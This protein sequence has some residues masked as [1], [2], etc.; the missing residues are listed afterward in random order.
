MFDRLRRDLAFGL[1]THLRTPLVTAV[2][3]CTLALGIASAGVSFSLMNALFI[4][5]LPI[6]GPDRFVRVY[7]QREGSPQ[8]LPISYRELRDLGDLREVFAGAVAEQPA[9][10]T[11]GAAGAYDRVWGEIV[12]ERY[13]ALLGVEPAYGRFFSTS[14]E[15][16]GE[17]VIVI[18]HG[19][20]QRRFGGNPEALNS[21]VRVDARLMRIIGVA[22]PAFRGTIVAFESDLWVPI[23]SAPTRHSETADRADRGYFVIARLTEDSG[24]GRAR[25]AVDAL[26]HRLQQEYPATNRGIRLIAF[27]ESE[28]RVPPPFRDGVLGFSTVAVAVAL[29]VTAIACANV[30]GM[31]L[32]RAAARRTEIG[33]RLALGASRRRIIAQ[34]LTEAAMLSLA[35][36]TIGVTVA[37]LLT[38]A[39]SRLQVPIARGA[40][41]SLDV[42]MDSRVLA[43]S[44]AV[45][46]L[47]GVLFGLVPALEASRPNLVGILKAGGPGS[48]RHRSLAG[49]IFLA[50]QIALSML[51]LITG[52]LFV[53][54]LQHGRAIDLGFDPANVV[55]SAVDIRGS[56]YSPAE[57]QGFWTT[58]IDEIRRLP[59]TES[60]SLTARLPLELGIVTLS[61]GPEGFQPAGDRGWPSSEFA[62]VDPDFFD[63]LRI[64]L[65][66]GRDFTDRDTGGA[67]PVIIVNDV[68]ARQFWGE[69]RAVGRHVINPEGERFE[70]VGEVR[71]SKYLSVG[72]DPKPYVYF[73]LRQGMSHAMTI[74]AR[75]TGDS[76][77]HIRAIVAAVRR[78]DP[79]APLFDVAP[80]SDRVTRSLAATSG[81]VA[82]LGIISLMA[83]ALTSLGLFGAVAQ[84][85][86]RRTYEIGVRRAL[87]A[88]DRNVIWVVV[89]DV[90][91][92]VAAGLLLGIALALV[93]G[94][95]L[96]VLLYNV[97]PSDPLVFF[98]APLVLL[99]VAL[100]SAWLP[101]YRATRIN[102]ATALRYD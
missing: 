29:L 83:L 92:L 81:G 5:P 78:F 70:V 16:I 2:V 32:A 43:V 75:G 84:S 50:A 18:S 53:R 36:G 52:G 8:V 49:R 6:Q 22:P 67:P 9:P 57:T 17:P 1:R 55:T 33:V 10:F 77:A 26:T 102:A 65:V 76:A 30:A 82:G 21:H 13:F 58:L 96:R 20:W 88:P 69:H 7:H 23:R 45:T 66:D 74:V 28:G 31:M 37:F 94:R 34:L 86:G 48:G 90:V 71:R 64:P 63:T 60:A 47:T 61:I 93:A 42:T 72:E 101:T 98:T 62:V 73:P 85:V 91:I 68:V 35:A 80:M 97:N 40:S 79:T 38:Q 87:G 11:L 27:P 100:V 25:A 46:V 54:S 12:S 14:E 59:M 24:A 44:F 3:V 41:L 95:A 39:V 19:L 99:L 56:G 4:R 51:L 89:R 15:E